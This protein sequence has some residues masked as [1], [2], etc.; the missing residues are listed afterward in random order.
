MG[1]QGMLVKGLEVSSLRVRVQG[2]TFPRPPIEPHLKEY[3]LD[4]AKPGVVLECRVGALLGL[5]F[6]GNTG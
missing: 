1:H 6:K 3:S 2:F 4:R 5:G